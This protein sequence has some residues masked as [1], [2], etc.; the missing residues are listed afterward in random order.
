[1]RSRPLSSC[2]SSG[3]STTRPPSS[4][5]YLAGPFRHRPG[6]GQTARSC[7]SVV[8]LGRNVGL[9]LSAYPLNRLGSGRGLIGY[10]TAKDGLTNFLSRTLLAT[11]ASV[12]GSHPALP[13]FQA[14]MIAGSRHSSCP[15]TVLA[16]MGS[17]T[18]HC[19]N[20]VVS[21]FHPTYLA[22]S[23]QSCSSLCSDS[24]SHSGACSAV[25]A[26]TCQGYRI[27]PSP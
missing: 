9:F 4:I 20:R 17:S 24:V 27:A 14:A 26:A 8:C 25:A 3:S 7:Q 19:L 23:A 11:A 12:T 22:P 2:T 5:H 16:S 18:S 21:P 15:G 1:M 10:S 13:R 6:W